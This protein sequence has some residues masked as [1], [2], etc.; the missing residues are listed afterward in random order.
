MILMGHDKVPWEEWQ[1][2]PKRFSTRLAAAEYGNEYF[3]DGFYTYKIVKLVPVEELDN[4][5]RFKVV[6]ERK[7]K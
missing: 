6:G 3:N 4:M 2:H 7:M 1:L 5:A